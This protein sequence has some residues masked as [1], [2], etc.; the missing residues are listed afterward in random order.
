MR[1]VEGAGAA[2][3][4]EA[5]KQIA[6]RGV[7]AVAHAQAAVLP[8]ALRQAGLFAHLGRVAEE[9]LAGDRENFGIAEAFEQRRQEIRRHPHVAVQ[10]HH[11]VVPGG[12]EPGVR[13]AAEAQVLRQRQHLDTAGNARA[14]EI[15]AAI[16][17]AVIHHDDLV[18]RVAG[19]RRAITE[20][21]Y[22]SSRSFPF[23]LGITTEA[24]GAARRMAAASAGASAPNSLPAQVRQRQRQRR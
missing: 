21:R 10:Q 1:A 2:A 5:G 19:Q 16:R 13:S 12:A 6:D 23:Q 15:R 9:D 24:A 3:A 8:P 22:F 18:V 7:D 17:R 4:V 11:D 20:G 14:H